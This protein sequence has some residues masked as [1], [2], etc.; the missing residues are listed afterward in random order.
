MWFLSKKENPIIETD[1]LEIVKLVGNSKLDYSVYPTVIEDIKALMKVRHVC[2]THVKKCQYISSY[3]L[4]NYART[5]GHTT[6]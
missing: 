5:N 6:A 1:F 2:I 3:Y 4:A